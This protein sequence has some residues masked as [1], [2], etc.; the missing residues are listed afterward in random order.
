MSA[1]IGAL[2]AENPSLLDNVLV[3]FNT[4]LQQLVHRA[5]ELSSQID[6]VS[7]SISTK[8]DQALV[9]SNAL[10]IQ[11]DLLKE[12]VAKLN[13]SLE[14]TT[15]VVMELV[16][17]STTK[18][19]SSQ[20]GFISCTPPNLCEKVMATIITIIALIAIALIIACIVAACGGFPLFISL[21]N[22][23][24]IG[25]CISLPILSCAA[26]AVLILSSQIIA[27]LLRGRPTIFIA[28]SNML[29]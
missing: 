20:K 11:V 10:E 13:S 28:Q 24:T 2:S 12:R 7:T 18:P 16:E 22:I 15:E 8:A 21:L 3:S 27:S 5:N 6:S 14:A 25:A 9:S 4:R 29:Y 19:S 23:Y 1:P 26:A 17:T